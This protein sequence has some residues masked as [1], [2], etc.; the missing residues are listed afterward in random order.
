MN[1]D[2]TLEKRSLRLATSAAP[3][4]TSVALEKEFWDVIEREARDNSTTIPKF[5]GTLRL[6]HPGKSL[7]SVVRVHCLAYASRAP[8]RTP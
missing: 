6:A 4:R 8:G 1:A 5:V 2:T 7:A 3:I